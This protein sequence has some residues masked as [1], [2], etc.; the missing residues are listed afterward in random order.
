MI[1]LCYI[2]NK[3][4]SEKMKKVLIMFA[5]LTLFVGCSNN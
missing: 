3:N 1:I 2:Y 4:R 5:M